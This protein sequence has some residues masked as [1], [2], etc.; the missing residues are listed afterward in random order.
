[1]NQPGLSSR[2]VPGAGVGGGRGAPRGE[3]RV[4]AALR[5]MA[6][7]WSSLHFSSFYFIALGLGSGAQGSVGLEL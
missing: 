4:W 7:Q 3:Q 6:L 5:S 2:Q 1:M